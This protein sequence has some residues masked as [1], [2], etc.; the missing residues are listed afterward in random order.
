MPLL[1]CKTNPLKRVDL[2]E[3]VKCFNPENR[4]NR[5][6]TWRP[7]MDSGSKAGMTVKGKE[8]GNTPHPNPLPRREGISGR[9]H[10]FDYEEK[11]VNT[12][13]R[14]S[15]DLQPAV[16]VMLILTV[17]LFLHCLLNFQLAANIIFICYHTEVFIS[18]LR[19]GLMN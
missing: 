2:D 16:Q 7:E 1:L 17:L 8:R 18:I 15:S 4:Y 9:W 12:G 19:L 14:I 11:S 3:F 13:I 6:P 5:T 10:D